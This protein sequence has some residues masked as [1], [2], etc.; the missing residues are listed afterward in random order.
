MWAALRVKD[1]A[2]GRARR[3]G[4][5]WCTLGSLDGPDV[6]GL[7]PLLPLA[8]VELDL[9]VLLEV[10]VALARDRAEVHENVGAAVV[11]SDEAEALLRAEP[12]D[13]TGGHEAFPPF[14]V[15]PSLLAARRTAGSRRLRE[16]LRSFS[17]CC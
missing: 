15:S 12:L 17:R 16:L 4:A 3:P 7:R 10:A 13:G 11:G 2:P 8:H 1:R 5:R 6:G 9:L 14:L